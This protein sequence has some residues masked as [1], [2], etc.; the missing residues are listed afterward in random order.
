MLAGVVEDELL[1][2][3]HDERTDRVATDRKSVV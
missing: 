2:L 3:L 1:P